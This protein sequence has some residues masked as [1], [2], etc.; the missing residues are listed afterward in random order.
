MD[1]VQCGRGAHTQRQLTEEHHTD[2]NDKYYAQ[3][4]AG[5]LVKETSEDQQRWEGH[6]HG[7][8]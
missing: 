4:E 8:V 7:R 3:R 2:R 5:V 6:K 1:G